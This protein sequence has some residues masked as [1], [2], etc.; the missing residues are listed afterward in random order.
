KLKVEILLD[1]RRHGD[2]IVSPCQPESKKQSIQQPPRVAHMRRW[3]VLGQQIRQW[4]QEHRLELAAR[5][6][7]AE[8]LGKPAR[9]IRTVVH[10]QRNATRA[11]AI[12]RALCL[13]AN[14]GFGGELKQLLRRTTH[15][16][17]AEMLVRETIRARLG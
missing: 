1:V 17:L 3:Q 15:D 12:E 11:R 5:M 7:L 13:G 10:D 9:E 8:F 2:G 14:R 6:A 4:I 16:T